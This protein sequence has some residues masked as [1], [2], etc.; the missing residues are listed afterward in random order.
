MIAEAIAGDGDAVVDYYLRIN[1]SAREEIGDVH[2]WEP[3]VCARTIAGLAPQRTE[4]PRAQWLTSGRRGASRGTLVP[5]AP[6]G[7][8]LEVVAEVAAAE[9]DLAT[10]RE[11]PAFAES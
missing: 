6:S 4:R 11:R 1:P 7:S 8:T 10:Q 9:Q 5:P 3:Y 2:R